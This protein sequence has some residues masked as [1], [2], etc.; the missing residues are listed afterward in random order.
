MVF[1]GGCRSF[2]IRLLVR[3]SA[4]V[5]DHGRCSVCFDSSTEGEVGLVSSSA[6]AGCVET[7][8]SLVKDGDG[9]RFGK[10]L[11]RSWALPPPT[12][13]ATA[14]EPVDLAE[15]AEGRRKSLD[16]A[17]LSLVLKSPIPSS[18]TLPSLLS[19]ELAGVAVGIARARFKLEM[20]L[21]LLA[22]AR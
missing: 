17:L 15:V 2:A 18:P 7:S 1:C 4:W 6:S 20:W 13:P 5:S 16:R 12:P 9:R 19:K 3:R 10:T 8:G 22:K 14:D 11:L 21:V